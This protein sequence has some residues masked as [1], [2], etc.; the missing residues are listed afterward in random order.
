MKGPKAPEGMFVLRWGLHN[1]TMV[2]RQVGDLLTLGSEQEV[3]AKWD[4]IKQHLDEIG[5]EVWF[6]SFTDDQGERTELAQSVPYR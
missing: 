1:G 4:E 3:R 5:R 2:S 6:A